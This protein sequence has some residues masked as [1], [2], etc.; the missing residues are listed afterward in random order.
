MKENERPENMD[1]VFVRETIEFMIP[2][3]KRSQVMKKL[4]ECFKVTEKI[5]IEPKEKEL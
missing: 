1:D 5:V 3:Q 4:R 2:L